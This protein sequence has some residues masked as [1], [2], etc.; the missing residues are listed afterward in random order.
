MGR[1]FDRNRASPSQTGV[2]AAEKHRILV[3]AGSA[4]VAA[5]VRRALE[6]FDVIVDYQMDGWRTVDACLRL[7]PTMLILDVALPD[8]TGWQV[9][10]RLRS[11]EPGA[12]NVRIV[13]LTSFAD[14]A[15]RLMCQL[16]GVQPLLTAPLHAERL[17]SLVAAALAG[18]S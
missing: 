1:P 17:R 5:V 8:M 10:Q 15:T 7:L 16:Q 13:L 4:G 11:A 14:P 2:L 9:V 12:P 6:G 3:A 18:E